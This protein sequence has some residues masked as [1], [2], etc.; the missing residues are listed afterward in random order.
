PR[1]PVAGIPRCGAPQVREPLRLAAGEDSRLAEVAER[2]RRPG[3]PTVRLLRLCERDLLLAVEEGVSG[4]REREVADQ[5]DES[6][7]RG[8]GREQ[9]DRAACA[10]AERPHRTCV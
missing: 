10:A 8:D 9:T 5:S 6:D 2:F 1:L 3:S 4:L 7:D